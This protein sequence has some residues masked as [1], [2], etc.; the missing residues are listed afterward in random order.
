LTR[1]A[2]N[3]ADPQERRAYRRELMDVARGVRRTGVALVVLG[4]A[5]ILVNAFWRPVPNLVIWPVIAVAF[6]LMGYGIAL[7]M[8]HHKRR[9]R[10]EG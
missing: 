8:R 1:P 4:A 7:R 3:L 9:M 2:P 10:G 6:A 5:L